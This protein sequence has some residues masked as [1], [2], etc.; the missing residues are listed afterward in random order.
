MHNNK[1]FSD[2]QAMA[3][4]KE[5]GKFFRRLKQEEVSYLNKFEN[6]CKTSGHINDESI[7]EKLFF[8]LFC[9]NKDEFFCNSFAKTLNSDF[10][11]FEKFTEVLMDFN[12]K[13]VELKEE[14]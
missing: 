8:K 11:L 12:S 10:I 1:L 3:Y 2:G 13:S 6:N 14:K 5:K 4:L 7:P 9:G